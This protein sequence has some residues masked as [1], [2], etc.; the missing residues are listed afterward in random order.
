MRLEY[1]C[2]IVDAIL[3][4]GPADAPTVENRVFGFSVSMAIE[5]CTLLATENCTL[6]GRTSRADPTFSR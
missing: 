5:N 1:T 2:L 6:F 3:S 4:G